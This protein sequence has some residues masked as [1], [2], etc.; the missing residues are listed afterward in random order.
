MQGG[1]KL[2]IFHGPGFPSHPARCLNRHSSVRDRYIP[3]GVLI[4]STVLPRGL[5]DSPAD[6]PTCDH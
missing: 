1:V 3:S 6:P 2:N 5:S 4:L